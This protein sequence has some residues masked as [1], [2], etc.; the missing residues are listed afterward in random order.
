[1]LRGSLAAAPQPGGRHDVTGDATVHRGSPGRDDRSDADIAATVNRPQAVPEAPA[2]APLDHSKRNLWLSV[3]GGA[4]LAVAVVVGVVLASSA[5]PKPVSTEGVSKPPADALDSGTVPDVEG[6]APARTPEDRNIVRFSWKNPQ[7][8]EGD[9]YK[10]RTK[11]AQSEG[12]YETETGEFTYVG[13]FDDD[14]PYCI[15]VI[16]VRSDGA[17]SPGGPDSIACLD[18]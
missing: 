14:L 7:P 4:V 6:L 13:V 16:I 5:A 18:R 8:K 2:E 1:M 12:P 9:T 17:A 15:Q 3:A 11:S 10:W